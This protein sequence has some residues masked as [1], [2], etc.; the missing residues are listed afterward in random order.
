MRHEL[1]RR[2]HAL[3]RPRNYLEIGV[4]DG[5]SLTLSRVPTVAVDPAF[6]VTVEQRCDL[7]LVR[8]TS[9]EF[10]ARPDPIPHLRS[11]RNPFK[12]VRRGRPL[13]GHYVGRTTVDLV[14]IDGLHLAEFALRDFMNVERFAHWGSTIV[15]D[16]MLPR[17]I[18][19]AARDRHTVDWTGD[20]YKVHAVLRQYRPDLTLILLDTGPTGTLV[21]FGADPGNTAL[22]ENYERIER[23]LI[24]GDPQQV[25]A[26]VLERRDAV[27]AEALLDASFWRDL[28]RDRNRG[29]SRAG[30]DRL[31]PHFAPLV[32]QVAVS[33]AGS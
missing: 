6:E 1:L 13:F 10:F 30:Y 5:R 3:A 9:D 16:D 25:P 31:R 22:T 2:L 7:H 23:D 14:F 17:D 4:G 12:N 29:A 19:E 20:V 33:S 27:A 26:S 21:V 28:V 18:D 24:V 15:F 32:R 8:A 11:S